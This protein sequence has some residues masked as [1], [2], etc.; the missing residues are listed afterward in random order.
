MD[1]RAAHLTGGTI[2][3]MSFNKQLFFMKSN[4]KGPKNFIRWPPPAKVAVAERT[5]SRWRD[6]R[7][8]IAKELEKFDK[9]RK[10]FFKYCAGPIRS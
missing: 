8:L 9:E 5:T 7:Q 10:R 1:Q 4:N 6:R 2:P 3:Q